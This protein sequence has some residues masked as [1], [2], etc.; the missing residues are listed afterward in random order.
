MLGAGI[1][2]IIWTDVPD[3]E[4]AYSPVVPTDTLGSLT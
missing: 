2:V 3:N 1:L 4:A